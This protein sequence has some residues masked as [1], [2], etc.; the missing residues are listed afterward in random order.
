M[1]H[2]SIHHIIF[3]QIKA[4]ATGYEAPDG[5]IHYREIPD[6]EDLF[7]IADRSVE[8]RARRVAALSVDDRTSLQSDADALEQARAWVQTRRARGY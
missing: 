8:V 2:R 5:T 3:E 1:P 6:V 7:E 4:V